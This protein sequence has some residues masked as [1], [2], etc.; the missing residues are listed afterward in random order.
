MRCFVVGT[1]RC[2]TTSFYQAAK[3]LEG[4]TAGHES[5]ENSYKD[6]GYPD[7]HVEVD[8]Q[9]SFFVP[10]LLRQYPDAVWVHLRRERSSCIGS[11]ARQNTQIMTA[12]AWQWL[13]LPDADPLLA[14]ARFYDTVND[15]LET[16]LP[17]ALRVDMEHL[18]DGLRRTAEALG[19]TCA[20]GMT[21]TFGR[22]YNHRQQRGRE[23]WVLR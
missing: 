13:Q 12:W 19:T 1:G 6:L 17:H 7:D 8:A 3:Y 23:A 22:I 10:A 20:Q 11:L 9:L 15:L 4:Y 18:P 14:A 2:G 16:L 5:G 21:A